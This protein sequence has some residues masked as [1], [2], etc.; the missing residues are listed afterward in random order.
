[1]E[2]KEKKSNF[3]GVAEG[4]CIGMVN[5][6]SINFNVDDLDELITLYH[7]VKN[8][9]MGRALCFREDGKIKLC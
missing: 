2:L 3:I 9:F 4:K 6:I 5:G 8:D 7:A 1:M